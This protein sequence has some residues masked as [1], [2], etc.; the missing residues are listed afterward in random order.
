MKGRIV[1]LCLLATILGYGSSAS[2]LTLDLNTPFGPAGAGPV[3]EPAWLSAT[4]DNVVGGVQL[5]LSAAELPNNSYVT[6]WYFNIIENNLVF[7]PVQQGQA[8]DPRSGPFI[9]SPDSLNAGTADPNDTLGHGFDISMTFFD[10]TDLFARGDTATFLFSSSITAGITAEWFNQLN[11]A[12]GFFAAAKI[13]QSGVVGESWFAAVPASNPV[14]EPAT[15]LLLGI[16]LTG[17]AFSG[18]KKF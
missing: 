8:T 16:G 5:T 12:G 4:F 17:L 9:W 10:T 14:P 1:F 6:Q 15:M 13:L 7:P 11:T 18:R 2:A 3:V